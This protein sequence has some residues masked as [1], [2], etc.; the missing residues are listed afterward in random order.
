[1]PK[2]GDALTPEQARLLPAKK[3]EIDK[4]VRDLD[5]RFRVRKPG[6]RRQIQ[7]NR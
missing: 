2:I 1:M 5:G 7:R 4:L 3:F 6:Q